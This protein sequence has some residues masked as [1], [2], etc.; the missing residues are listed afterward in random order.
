MREAFSTLQ[1]YATERIG[2]A[3]AKTQTAFPFGS[4]RISIN[5]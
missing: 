4:P 5:P 2:T 3:L 1:L